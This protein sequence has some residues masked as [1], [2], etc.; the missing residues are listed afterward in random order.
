MSN[1]IIIGK[2]ITEN[3]KSRYLRF[4][5]KSFIIEIIETINNITI[6]GEN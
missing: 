4:F 2:K 6:K 1:I 3:I 5:L